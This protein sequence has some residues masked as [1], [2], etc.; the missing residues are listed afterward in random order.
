M[1]YQK[2]SE[3]L[4]DSL[5]KQP[6]RS[7]GELPFGR[8]MRCWIKK[9]LDRQMEVLKSMGFWRCITSSAY[10]SGNTVFKRGICMDRIKGLPGLKA[11]QENHRFFLMDE[12]R[13]PSGFAG[14]L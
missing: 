11:K 12:D 13:W 7:I 1:L 2:E 3:K 4:E 14:G 8:G 9:E 10:R 5:F 6:Q